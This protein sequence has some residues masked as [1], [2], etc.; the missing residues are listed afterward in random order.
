MAAGLQAVNERA[1]A[2]IHAAR[3]Q[4][5]MDAPVAPDRT[6]RGA[7]AAARLAPES[8]TQ[9]CSHVP[10]AR[11]RRGRHAAADAAA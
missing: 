5:Q 6:K 9:E 8:N 11:S 4:A 7:S 1:G 10:A 3:R 2:G